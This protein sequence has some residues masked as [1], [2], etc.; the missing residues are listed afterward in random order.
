MKIKYESKKFEVKPGA[1]ITFKD[2]CY[3]TSSAKAAFKV[4]SVEDN[5]KFW[6]VYCREKY[7]AHL[8]DFVEDKCILIPEGLT[9]YTYEN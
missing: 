3:G 8:Y 2:E 1:W 6:I 9:K 7:N 5:G 4:H